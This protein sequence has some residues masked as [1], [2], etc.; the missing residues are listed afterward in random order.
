MLEQRGHQSEA[1][2]CY[3]QALLVDPTNPRLYCKIAEILLRTGRDQELCGLAA[4]MVAVNGCGPEDINFLARNLYA[5]GRERGL[6]SLLQF[7]VERWPEDSPSWCYLGWILRLAGDLQTTRA[8]LARSM[9]S[10]PYP[11]AHTRL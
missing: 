3:R 1:L 4:E 5:S 9:R 11:Y 6:L 7:A 10:S 2:L 8:Q